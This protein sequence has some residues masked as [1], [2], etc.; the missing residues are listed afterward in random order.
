MKK[1]ILIFLTLMFAIFF[2]AC[3]NSATT[4]T[5]MAAK[6]STGDDPE[7]VKAY[8]KQEDLRFEEEMSKGD[9]TALAAHYGSDAIVMPPNSEIVKGSDVVHAWGGAIRMGV[10]EFKLNTTDISGEGNFYT[11]TGTFEMLGAGSKSLDKG[12]YL[13]MWKKDNGNWKIYRD[14]W[15][16]NSAPPAS[17]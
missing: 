14:I 9:S 2:V 15:N 17:K 5:K 6:D 10:K 12:K 11:E 1:S 3:N 13:T 7:R 4:D 16:S 8:L